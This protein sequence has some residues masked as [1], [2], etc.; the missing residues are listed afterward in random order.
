MKKILFVFLIVTILLLAQNEQ[1]KLFTAILSD[2]VVNGLVKYKELKNDKRLDEYLNQL[3][4][5]DPEK[6]SNKNDKLSFWIN[7]Y[8][9]FTLKLI[10]ENYPVESI[11]DLHT[12]GLI[13]GQLLS[14]TVWH[15]EWIK[16]GGKTLSLNNIEHDIIRKEFTEPRIHF[17]LVCAALSCPPLRF[18][19]FEGYKLNQQL[20]DQ[21][22]KFFN[23]KTKN[24]F[25]LKTK[26]AKLSKILGWYD[27][28]FGKN[29]EEILKY[30]S[31]FLHAEI[32][33]SINNNL[34]EWEIE[35][36]SYDWSLNE[37]N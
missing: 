9:A 24:Q 31:Q 22:I 7:A 14:K 13:I 1:H 3:S 21:A 20:E 36:L 23:D 2:Y 33:K 35:Y 4:Q 28:D 32:S 18:E 8:N 5:I 26:T 27:E 12:G 37:I 17:A 29:D 16:I 11:N 15:K 34:S 25:D 10:S 19:A 30:V 6:I